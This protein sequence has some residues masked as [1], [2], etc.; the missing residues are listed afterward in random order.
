M[1]ASQE[2][3][4]TL[5]PEDLPHLGDVWRRAPAQRPALDPGLLWWDVTHGRAS[6]PAELA[7]TALPLLVQARDDQ[8]TA[9]LSEHGLFGV[10]MPSDTLERFCTG[11]VSPAHL[12]RLVTAAQ[13][14]QLASAATASALAETVV[15]S[16]PAASLPPTEAWSRPLVGV[17]DDGCAFL[18]PC[19]AETASGRA[20]GE[21]GRS[22]VRWLWD[23]DRVASSRTM[24]SWGSTSF[25]Y[26]AELTAAGFD[27]AHA[28]A[29]AGQ[30]LAGYH[31][32]EYLVDG[33]GQAP[34]LS[35]GTFVSG[36]VAGNLDGLL[37][38]G[39]GYRGHGPAVNSPIAFVGLP[40]AAMTDTSGRSLAMHLLSGIRYVLSKA[41]RTQPVVI[42]VSLG[43]HGGPHDG[44]DPLSGA[45]SALVAGEWRRGRPLVIVTGAGNGYESNTHAHWQNHADGLPHGVSA[46]W[47]WD[48]PAGDPTDSY[49]NIWSE[50]PLNASVTTPAGK[51]SSV[52]VAPHDAAVYWKQGRAIGLVANL[53]GA[54]TGTGC[55]I[56]VAVAPTQTAD[57]GAGAPAGAWALALQNPN[58]ESC[59]WD[60]WVDRDDA[61]FGQRAT[62]RAQSTLRDADSQARV[63]SARR[64]LNG[65]ACPEHMLVASA[66][67]LG[68]DALCTYSA[69]GGG[70]AG[71]ADYR[72]LL[73][74]PADES[75]AVQGLPGPGVLSGSV[76]RVGGTSVASAL[77]ARQAIAF[78]AMTPKPADPKAFR[79]G[80]MRSLSLD[81]TVLGDELRVGAGVARMHL[82]SGSPDDAPTTAPANS[83][84][85]AGPLP[86]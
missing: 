16:S 70:R 61:P 71:L 68:G 86:S 10:P 77:L 12:A 21:P 69:S 1:S 62:S 4:R 76:Q 15:P 19:F 26:G 56:Q 32:I 2:G 38:H 14:V 25:G 58:A 85:A 6:T 35:H 80:L 34:L 28:A 39:T 63:V 82:F 18:N 42:N 67:L 45:L 66:A 73:A 55:V 65:L 53:A 20:D 24:G 29:R 44:S 30:E 23:Q 47:F 83:A 79:H 31:A 52:T 40:R 8:T 17:I 37:H 81:S 22:R 36:L 9:K 33:V 84:S 46:Q 78:L 13:R 5:R 54:A 75:A 64:T 50:H 48:L 27:T 72:P 43:H 49:M 7:S 57:G 74:M 41:A 51:A 59:D 60:A 3:W 11:F